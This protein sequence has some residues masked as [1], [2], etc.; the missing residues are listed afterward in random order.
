MGYLIT[1]I[2]TIGI[3]LTYIIFGLIGLGLFLVFFSTRESHYRGIVFFTRWWAK[4]S[5][6][7]FNIKIHRKDSEKISPGSLIVANHVGAP[8]IFVMGSCFPAFFVSKA[9]IGRWPFMSWLTRLGATIFVDRTRK[10]QVRATIDQIRN[11]MESQCSVI[12]FPEAQATDGSDILPFKSSHFEAAIQSGQPVVPVIIHYQDNNKPSVA[13]WYDIDFMTHITRL[14]KCPRLN[15]TVEVLPPFN[16][17]S[18]R[19]ILAKKCHEV[20]REK[21][22]ASLEN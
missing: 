16:G 1:V 11:R 3:V 8:D 2:R 9:E 13:C 5:C 19:R 14:L 6:I 7:L 17:E 20:I 15:A 21:Y 22:R 18:D 10:Q 12:L 4:C